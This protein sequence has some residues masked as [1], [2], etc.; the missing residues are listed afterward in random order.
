MYIGALLSVCVMGPGTDWG[1][2]Q[3]ML[4]I[5]SRVILAIQSYS[6]RFLHKNSLRYLIST[7]GF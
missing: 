3:I 7:K 2:G 5:R 6:L 4:I 1:F